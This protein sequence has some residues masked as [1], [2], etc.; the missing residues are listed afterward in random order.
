M[1]QANKDVRE[2]IEVSGFKYWQ[3]AYKLNLQDCNFSRLLRQELPSE[4]KQQI[5]NIIEKL[6]KEKER[7]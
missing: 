5:L 4:K 1:E 7:D 3:V 2:A 6:K